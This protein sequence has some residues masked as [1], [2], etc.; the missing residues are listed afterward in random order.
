MHA[1]QPPDARVTLAD[2]V[3][4]LRDPGS[5]PEATGRVETV[6]THMSWVFLTDLHAYKLK[7]PVRFDHQD[8]RSLAV[9]RFY[10]EEELRLNRRLAE[11]VYLDVV[12]LVACSDGRVRVGGSGITIDWLVKM[13]RLRADTMLDAVLARGDVTAPQ[14]RAV[15]AR[16]ADF[17][18][19]QPAAPI[20]AVRY[21]TLLARRID[22]DERDLCERAAALPRERISG[23]CDQQRALLRSFS[24]C[25]EARVDAG[26]VIECHGDLRPEHIYLG[27]PMAIIDCL[28]FSEELRWLDAADEIGFLA[29]ECER[30]RAPGAGHALLR[31]WREASGDGVPESLVHFYQSCRACLRARLAIRHL[32]E[33]RYRDSPVWRR[34]AMRYLA[35]A[36]RHLRACVTTSPPA[37]P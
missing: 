36:D 37:A 1:L 23:L 13:R 20:D 15:A 35:L 17:H 26:R 7:K 22:D 21:R 2:K 24:A 19:R 34:R 3:T 33:A 8:F 31:C 32:R 4:A 16:L 14:L 18:R 27:E 30:V 29:L 12:P 11:W 10:C 25:L 9:R 6:E 5:Y 28:E